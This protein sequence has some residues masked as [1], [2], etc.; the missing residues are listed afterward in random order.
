MI[1][2]RNIFCLCA[3]AAFSL[4]GCK[5][6]HHAE[7]EFA[8]GSYS[9]PLDKTG[10]KN[11]RGIYRWHDGSI[12]EGDYRNDMRHGE[13]RFLWANGETYI[14]EYRNDERTG[15]GVYLWPDGSRYEGDFIN[16]M[17]HGRGVFITSSGVIYEGE[18]FD[19]LQH[20]A[21]TLT[22]PD[23]RV[24]SGIW[25]Q[26]EL[27]TKPA[28]L[29]PKSTKPMPISA[30]PDVPVIVPLKEKPSKQ[31][32]N[33]KYDVTDE[34]IEPYAQAS[35]SGIS[36]PSLNQTPLVT[37][38]SSNKEDLFEVPVHNETKIP[39]KKLEN[40]KFKTS[41]TIEEEESPNK[42]DW[43]GT[44]A[45]AEIMF[46]TELDNGL[47]TIRYRQNGN[48]FTGNMRIIDEQGNAQGEVN[49][50]NGRLHGEEIFFNQSGDVVERNF[51]ANGKPVVR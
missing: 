3:L 19:D 29:P 44:V 27:V 20:G 18:W 51:W 23:G 46:I 9:G 16:G 33:K 14:G 36:S 17:R 38:D 1:G 42:P 41:T 24:V 48:T 30:L 8:D 12:Y 5:S 4:I 39:S 13:G 50:L 22:Y 49:L 26:G 7:V 25:R 31:T 35:S 43:M 6:T 11:G 2:I 21:G 34:G 47:D 28:P 32:P 10:K 37:T 15:K 40:D 45:E